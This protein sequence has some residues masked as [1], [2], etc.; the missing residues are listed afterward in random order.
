MRRF[1]PKKIRLKKVEGNESL[2]MFKYVDL[3]PIINKDAGIPRKALD[4]KIWEI[5]KGFYAMEPR[6]HKRVEIRLRKEPD[7]DIIT[8]VCIKKSSS[9]TLYPIEE[10]E[11]I[12]KEALDSKIWNI[13][14]GYY[15]IEF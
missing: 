10:G 1:I 7:R 2:L 9:V 4:P 6:V 13:P 15:A 12:P 14:E 8:P 3:Y 5:P 11:E